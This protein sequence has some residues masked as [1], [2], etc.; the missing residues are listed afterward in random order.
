MCSSPDAAKA[1]FP[2]PEGLKTMSFPWFWAPKLS[3]PCI[4]LGFGA[5]GLFK[6][7]CKRGG[8]APPFALPFPALSNQARGPRGAVPQRAG[9]GVALSPPTLRN[10]A[11]GPRG[12]YPQLLV[13][14]LCLGLP[15]RTPQHAP[16]V[17]RSS[18]PATPPTQGPSKLAWAIAGGPQAQHAK[19]P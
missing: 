11:R 5:T 17:A 19:K 6:P 2:G 18:A 13:L 8:P 15:L 1:R 7:R 4:F 16:R 10:Q 9:E 12:A 14:D 3:K